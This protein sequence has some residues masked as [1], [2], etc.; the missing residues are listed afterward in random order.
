MKHFCFDKVVSNKS[1]IIIFAHCKSI[2]MRKFLFLIL[3]ISFSLVGGL[4]ASSKPI[5]SIP[6][7][8]VGS[9]IVVQA[10]INNSSKLK[11]ILDTGVRRTIITELLEGDSIDLNTSETVNMQGLGEGNPLTALL[12]TDNTISLSKKFKLQNKPI[13]ILQEKV[14]D[15]TRQTG[16]KINGL[17]GVDFFQNYI[18]QIDYI[19]CRLKFY[20]KDAFEVPKDYG[21]MPML[22]EKQKMYIQLSVLETDTTRRSIKML[23]DTGAELNAWFQTLSNQA[24]SIPE[25]S[26]H[27][28]IGYGLNGEV[29]GVFA[30]VPQI[31][32]ASSC[33]KDPIVVFPD[34]ASISDII[35]KTDRDGTIGS[36]LLNRFNIIIDTFNKR[37]FFKPNANFNKPFTYNIAGIEVA[38]AIAFLPQIEVVNV[39]KDSPADR[40]GVKTGDV[41]TEIDDVKVY[42][43][44]LPQVKGYFIQP[45]KRPLRLLI[46]RESETIALKID[47]KAKI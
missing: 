35:L 11:F 18:V 9:Y 3:S 30:R 40:A 23:I 4:N 47:M 41:I 36:Q 45:S 5:V 13:Y 32:I 33:V 19:G 34:S 38:Q 2:V 37:F 24:I 25:K 27:G 42:G 17:L 29:N 6:F 44:T 14:F 12:S 26:I 1:K 22:C 7:E 39:W 10:R 16:T 8:K 21:V 31:C 46:Q 15:L 28:R 43:L 20:E